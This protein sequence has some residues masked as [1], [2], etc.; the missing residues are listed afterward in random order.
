[1]GLKEDLG[2]EI[3]EMM[4]YYVFSI[5]GL[6]SKQVQFQDE[7]TKFTVSTQFTVFKNQDKMFIMHE[8]T[9]A[10]F[11]NVKVSSGRIV[12]PSF[13]AK[14]EIEGIVDKYDENNIV[15]ND[16]LILNLL[17]SSFVYDGNK[18]LVFAKIPKEDGKSIAEC[19]VAIYD[20]N[21]LTEEREC[22]T[23]IPYTPAALSE[24]SNAKENENYH[25]H[26]IYVPAEDMAYF[27]DKDRIVKIDSIFEKLAK[28]YN[29]SNA[30]KMVLKTLS[31][32]SLDVH[33]VF[34][35]KVQDSQN[36]K[37]LQ[38]VKKIPLNQVLEDLAQTIN[39]RESD[40][41]LEKEI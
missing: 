12:E 29:V 19:D 9:Q 11:F 32:D 23:D 6:S 31:S 39:A 38:I 18:F 35:K 21:K 3:S 20:G 33:L 34:Y 17:F 27:I 4:N 1:M 8:P 2:I 13:L 41:R 14:Q 7:E 24:D 5:M 10:T 25:R 26:L 40:T 15:F 22:Y 16:R 30:D 28:R 36:N 37:K